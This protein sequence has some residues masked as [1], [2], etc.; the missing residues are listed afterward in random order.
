MSYTDAVAF[1]MEDDESLR[2]VLHATY[3]APDR[4]LRLG[5]GVPPTAR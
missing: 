3:Q 5:A 2:E 4:K 1:G